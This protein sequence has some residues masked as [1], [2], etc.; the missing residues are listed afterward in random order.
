MKARKV[1]CLGFQ[2]TGTS[3]LDIALTQLGYEVVVYDAFR[4]LAQK[5][6]LTW[7]EIEE[8][9][10]ELASKFDAAKDTPWPLLYKQLDTAYPGSRLG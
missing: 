9:A 4:D 3:S 7:A 5:Q 6:G 10:L 2:K 1:F 8:R